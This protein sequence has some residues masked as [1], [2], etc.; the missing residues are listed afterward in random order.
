MIPI[1]N[2]RRFFQKFMQQ[3]AY[4]VRVGVQRLAALCAYQWGA[5]RAFFPEAVTLFLTYRCNLHCKMCG[6]WGETGVS[7]RMPSTAIR[8]ELTTQE[9]MNCIDGVAGFK[10]SITLFGGEPFLHQDVTAL[11]QRIKMHGMHCVVIT[12]GSLLAEIAASVV[13]SGLD[14]LNISL[15]GNEVRHD[16]I[17]G[18]VGLFARIASG[19]KEINQEKKM[20]GVRK[21]LINVQCTITK[22]NQEFLEDMLNVAKELEVNSV[23]FH[24]LIFLDA[25]TAGKQDR[26]EKE[27]QCSYAAWHGFVQDPGINPPAVYQKLRAM[28]GSR[29]SFKIDVY[30][31]FSQKE[32]TRYYTDPAYMPQE[33]PARCLSPWLCAYVFPDGEVRPCLNGTYSFGNIM[34][35]KLSSI[36][37][38]QK[39]CSFRKILKKQAVFPACVRCTEL[40]RY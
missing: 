11:I 5:G 1:K 31:N 36:W 18:M 20:Q 13:R 39:A 10:P 12:N 40:Y 21:P 23:T 15:D 26:W 25:E 29:H 16:H 24:N 27:L 9:L 8:R 19:I 28:A 33:Y 7:K 6:Q 2:F 30:P 34:H 3:P 17:R 32:M 14:E 37:N 22:Y 4:A 35:E 38:S